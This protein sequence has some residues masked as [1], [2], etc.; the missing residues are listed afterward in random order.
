M[1]LQLYIWKD[2]DPYLDEIYFALANS[3][4]QAIAL[5]EGLDGE[6]LSGFESLP[7]KLVDCAKAF[8]EYTN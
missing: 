3:K 6:N 2:P 5:L 7:F 1:T 4:E 8:H